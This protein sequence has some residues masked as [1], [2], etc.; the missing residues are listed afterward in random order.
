MNLSGRTAIVT[1]GASG[2]GAAY[3]RAYADAGAQVVIADVQ[4]RVGNALA[5]ELAGAGAQARFVHTDVA[6]EAETEALAAAALDA[7]GSIDVLVNNAALYVAIGKKKPLEDITVEEWDR[8]MAVNARGVWLCMKAV[9]PVMRR[10][11]QGRIVNIA[12]GVV[13]AGVPYF[14]HYL[15]SKA[16][17]IGITRS[18][19]R[20][21]GPDGITVNAIAPGLVANESSEAMNGRDY[22][23]NAVP[24]RAIKRDM[25]PD[26]L[27]GALMFL[28]SDA[29]AFITGQTFIVDGGVT[30]Q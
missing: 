4:D 12:S 20:E 13:H 30:M 19:A 21:L 28:S 3:V 7:F 1:G 2:I 27:V 6:D 8:V 26:D 17:V 18:S 11:G 24:M 9:S 29:S 16:A 25:L 22:L 14:C 15:A 10:Q 23:D 5:E